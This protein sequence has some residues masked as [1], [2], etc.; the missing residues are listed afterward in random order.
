MLFQALVVVWDTGEKKILPLYVFGYGL[1]A[2]ISILTLIIV[3][4]VE[5]EIEIGSKTEYHPKELCW[6][7]PKYIYYAFLIPVA[8]CLLYNTYIFIRGL[9]ITYKVSKIFG[10]MRLAQQQKRS[11]ESKQTNLI[12]SKSVW[13]LIVS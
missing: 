4:I 5:K 7:G 13:F 10:Q 9:L 8:L 2:F 11:S 6:L 12:S 1:P 3:V